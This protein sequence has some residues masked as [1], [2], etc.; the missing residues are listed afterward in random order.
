MFVARFAG[1]PALV[2]A[3]CLF[4]AA[5]FAA[6]ARLAAVA[7]MHVAAP[8]REQQGRDHHPGE[9]QGTQFLSHVRILLMS[10]FPG[11]GKSDA[12]IYTTTVSV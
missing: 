12:P 5:R 9:Q 1:C 7:M 3:G 8:A 11:W 2:A 4:L 6:P 10:I